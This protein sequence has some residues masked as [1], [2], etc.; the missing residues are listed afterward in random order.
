MKLTTLAFMT[1]LTI[2]NVAHAGFTT[3]FPTISYKVISLDN[4][5]LKNVSISYKIRAVKLDTCG[6]GPGHSQW[7]SR[8]CYVQYVSSERNAI[9]NENGE[10]TIPAFSAEDT[11]MTSKDPYL[12]I[13]AEGFAV[14]LKLDSGKKLNCITRLPMASVAAVGLNDQETNSSVNFTEAAAKK[15]AGKTITLQSE[16]DKDTMIK[17]YVEQD[18]QQMQREY[19]SMVNTDYL[20]GYLTDHKCK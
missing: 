4:K 10:V 11:A 6:F 20:P 7:F 3:S 8:P 9:T 13:T 15:Y 16:F 19:D 5:P 1:V 18:S 12:S 17:Y 2:T 14:D